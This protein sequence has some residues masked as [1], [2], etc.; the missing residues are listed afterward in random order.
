MFDAVGG[1][2]ESGV[3]WALGV[4]FKGAALLL[5]VFLA[6]SALRRASASLRHLVWGG[7]IAAVLLLPV[8]TLVMPWRIGVVPEVL[9]GAARVAIGAETQAAPAAGAPRQAAV[10]ARTGSAPDAAA[11]AGPA[12]TPPPA[13]PAVR[14]QERS[15]DV[16]GAIGRWALAIWAVGAALVLAR[17]VLGAALL[18]RVVRRAAPLEAPDWTHPLMEAA[19]RM[20]LDDLPRLLVSDGVPMPVVCGIAKPAIVMPAAAR[21]WTDGRRRAVLCHEIAHLRRRDLVVNLLGRL[22]C[23]IHWF[24]PLVWYAAWRLRIESERACDDMV[25][26]VGTRPSEY[27]DHL[28]Q[29]VCVAARSRTP[30]V[31]LPMAERRVFEGRMLAI[32]ERDARRAPPSLRQA[33]AVALLALF[34][35]LPLAAMGTARRTS[36]G[37]ERDAASRGGLAP[38]AARGPAEQGRPAQVEGRDVGGRG[39]VRSEARDLLRSGRPGE[40]QSEKQG[41]AQ[42]DA[43]AQALAERL[44]VRLNALAN[45]L[46]DAVGNALAAASAQSGESVD[47]RVVAALVRALRDS[48]AEV[49]RDAASALGRL[50]ARGGVAALGERLRR[51]PVAEVRRAAAWALG[52]IEDGAAVPDLAG[53]LDDR[54]EDVREMAIWALGQ[55][56]DAS[57]VAPLAEALGRDGVGAVRR[58]IVWALGQ[59]EDRSATGPLGARLRSD[60]DAEVRLMAAW[61]LGQIED[62]TAVPAL[63]AAVSDSSAPVRAMAVWAM[64]QIESERAVGALAEALRD[65]SAAVRERAAWALGQIESDAAVPGLAAALRDQE[66]Q[67]RRMALWA[68]GQIDSPA[69]Y[70]AIADALQGADAETRAAAVRAI[71]RGGANPMPMPMPMPRPFP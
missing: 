7:G 45:G 35:S 2:W 1:T 27:A 18:R 15:A 26:G 17:L 9:V 24:N 14:S 55:I 58:M 44:N 25:I 65:N 50:E 68:L 36:P 66:A 53:A 22:A 11:Q 60:R 52:Q 3:A 21:E 10:A 63:A 31:A 71:G 39:P 8:V 32:L 48:V 20:E 23:A 57:A 5:F 62:E 33:A 54:D 16:A 47:P 51:D 29:I 49:R 61:A 19:D 42:G 67:V 70:T 6:A 41:D 43:Q 40:A 30:A 56:E 13:Q 4:L 64:G 28:L 38:G 34:V 59:I 37:A 12:L 46:G 69:A